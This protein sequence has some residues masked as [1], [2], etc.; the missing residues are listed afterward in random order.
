MLAKLSGIS[1][2]TKE[3]IIST[4]I[5]RDIP[6]VKNS[7]HFMIKAYLSLRMI[8]INDKSLELEIEKKI[9][10]NGARDLRT[11]Y[12]EYLFA[13]Y[14]NNKNISE[15][16]TRKLKD[17]KYNET[18]LYCMTKVGKLPSLAATYYAYEILDQH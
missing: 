11:L 13:C 15:T 17:F 14:T 5:Y 6:F 10:Q 12:Y 9:E 3:K 2:G 7:I 1:V 18:E 4:S 8:G 16:C